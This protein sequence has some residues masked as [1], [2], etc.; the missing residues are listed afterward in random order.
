MAKFKLVSKYTPTGDQ[1]QAIAS[2]VDGVKKGARDQVLLGV[3]GS[4]KTFTMANVIKQLGKPALVIAHNKTLAAQL[5]NEFRAYFP[6]NRVEY[7]VSYYDYYQPEAYL[8]STDTYI[9]KDMAINSEIDK[10]RHSATCSLATRKDV[11]IVASVSCIYGL[12]GPKNYYDMA[13]SLRP[14]EKM[15]RGQLIN[16]L[17]KIQYKR[18]GDDIERS[19]FRSKGDVV[20]IIPSYTTQT[21]IRVCFMGDLIESV[22]EMDALTMTTIAAVNHAAIF[23]A[24]HY[25]V[26][27]DQLDGAIKQIRTDLD[28]RLDHLKNKNLM[29]EEH[30]LRQRTNYDIEMIREMGHCTGIENYSRYFDGRKPGEPPYTLVSYFGDDFIT[31]IDESHITVPQIRGMYNG[32]RAR[33]TTLVDFGFRLPSAFDNRPLNFTEFNKRIGQT[34]YVSATPAEYEVE[35]ADGAVIEQVIRPTGLVDPEIFIRPKGNQ[36]TDLVQEIKTLTEKRRGEVE[37]TRSDQVQRYVGAKVLV[38]TLTKKMAEDL[39]AHMTSNG[40]RVRYLHSDIHTL[41]R[42]DL[43]QALRK[44]EFDVV[45]GI[46][47]LREGLDIPEVELVA[48]LD[49][50]KEGLFRSRRSLIQTIGRAARNAKARVILYADKMTDS[51]TAA[52]NETERRRKIQQA[53]N[54][55]HGITPKTVFSESKNTLYVTDKDQKDARKL[56]REQIRDEIEKLTALMNIASRSLDFETAIKFREEITRLKG[57]RG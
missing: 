42:V 39:T 52:I 49:A 30:R 5:C 15:T 51:M 22:T 11:I 34:I 50:D 21:M 19:T 38:T 44:D 27:S 26:G 47:L 43:I 16:N 54:K 33:K 40:I 37:P 25:V 3:T 6:E 57:Q 7:F 31:F 10:L 29:I 24:T 12:G 13:I 2:L 4:G 18:A 35:R 45:V 48:I 28:D 55:K 56:S 23:P 14:G 9:E 46:N 8:P 36:V 1:P 53:Y 20:D 41:E 32:D 17:V